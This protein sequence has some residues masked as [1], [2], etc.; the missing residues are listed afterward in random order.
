MPAPRRNPSQTRSREMVERILLA[1]AR[2]LTERGYQDASTNRI[3][4]EAGVSPG[5]LYHY[6]ADKDAI[7]AELTR[8][9]VSDF[10]GAIAPALRRAA[11]EPPSSATPIVLDAVLDALQQQAGLLRALVDR[12]PAVEQK[13]ALQSVRM[14]LSDLVHHT[15]AT[16]QQA[17]RDRDIERLTWSI[18]EITQHMLVR[19]VLDSPPIAREDF[20][21]DTA[22]IVLSLAYTPAALAEF[23]GGT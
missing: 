4:Q 7:V 9:L 15:L 19:Y 18:V 14:H 8:R 6:F 16:R 11:L 12:V 23:A 3:A 13:E 1:G 10:A 22:H 21:E 2:V 20:L 5:S 17:L